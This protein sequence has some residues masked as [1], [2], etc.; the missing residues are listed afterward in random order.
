MGLSHRFIYIML[1]QLIF[2]WT[3]FAPTV[4]AEETPAAQG[5][6]LEL[7]LSSTERNIAAADYLTQ[8]AQ[9]TISLNGVARTV[10]PIDNLTVAEMI[11]VRQVLNTGNQY[12]QLNEFGAA[13]GGGF[14]L[15]YYAAN[16]I[17][18]LVIPEGVRASQNA[19]MLQNLN[20]TGNLTNNGVYNVFSSNAAV[21]AASVNA[22]NIY[23]NVG[24]TI[25]SS[26]A[27]LT[28]N[29]VND[30][31]NSGAIVTTGSIAMTAGNSIVNNGILQALQNLSVQAAN[32]TNQA[33]MAA[34][35]GNITV[36][37]ANMINNGA[38]QSASSMTGGQIQLSSSD[39]LNSLNTILAGSNPGITISST[40]NINTSTSLN[41]SITLTTNGAG[42]G[43]GNGP[44]TLVGG[45]VS[46]GSLSINAA[47][48]GTGDAGPIANA[49]SGT[50]INLIS[51]SN[52]IASTTIS[53]DTTASSGNTS[54]SSQSGQIQLIAA[55]NTAALNS[56]DSGDRNSVP[57]ASARDAMTN[58]TNT[59]TTLFSAPTTTATVSTADS[60]FVS[61]PVIS[62]D[63]NAITPMVIMQQ[64]PSLTL[65]SATSSTIMT[66]L[67]SFNQA[68]LVPAVPANMTGFTSPMSGPS[69]S[70]A[71]PSVSPV[72]Y[73]KI[74]YTSNAPSFQAIDK[75]VNTLFEI[76]FDSCL[77][78]HTGNSDISYFTT[79]HL[80]LNFGEILIHSTEET[81]V[82]SGD[83]VITVAPGCIAQIV[84]GEKVLK[85]RALY[86]PRAN[87]II[88]R[89]GNTAIKLSTGQEAS[90]APHSLH[91]Q[92]ASKNE[93]L[94]RRHLVEATLPNGHAMSRSEFS[95]LSLMT[96]PG[97]LNRLVYSK[98][99]D[100]RR[101]A[102]KVIKM[103]ACL[104]TATAAHG[105]Y[106]G[107]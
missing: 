24:A 78:K 85:V 56:G 18:N 48:N 40:T 51:N 4:L 22:T 75:S 1:I 43:T 91:L 70:P 80:N 60:N 49:T 2:T 100:D 57:R 26:I 107:K 65:S 25:N 37:T 64:L 69:L 74:A 8:A 54:I 68:N 72:P 87:S 32:I 104:M 98:A 77:V 66:T 86:E 102:D 106:S 27:N 14:H 97:V 36:V 76:R 31:V 67:T 83:Y 30:I 53:F 96:T 103:T 39:I 5:T 19:A 9:A 89:A 94:G 61:R 23:N 12:L 28:L 105:A 11:A 21:T 33:Q 38:I 13:N 55:D 52:G 16:G 45:P 6:P 3:G 101:L 95:P 15:S 17:T 99:I 42:T 84:K 29:A 73:Q 59:A 82:N 92:L 81:I 71:P 50:A 79:G 20:L 7:D 93:N 46:A 88:V 58:T 35:L 63:I 41:G 90:F 47:G 44:I 10:T 62:T 34:I